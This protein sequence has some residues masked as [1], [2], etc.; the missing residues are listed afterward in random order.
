PVCL[1]RHKQRDIQYIAVQFQ[2]IQRKTNTELDLIRKQ[3]LEFL[4]ASACGIGFRFDFHWKDIV[5]PLNQ[6]I[7]LIRRVGLR[8]V[9]WGYLK[10]CQQC[11]EDKVFSQ[12][13]F[14]FRK[15]PVA[16]SESS[17]CQ[18]CQSAQDSYV[19]QINLES[20]QVIICRHGK[21]GSGAAV[22]LKHQSCIHQP[23]QGIVVFPCPCTFFD[24]LVKKF[25]VLPC[26]LR[27]K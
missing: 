20:G 5:F 8:P 9:P 12:C 15:Q 13:P 2:I 14:E 21:P 19:H 18:L 4:Q 7:H 16:F 26:K 27:R 1:I 6:K 3:L 25:F 11:L 23:L 24:H 22:D 10:L 17:R